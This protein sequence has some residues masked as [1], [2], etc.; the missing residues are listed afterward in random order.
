MPGR[1]NQVALRHVHREVVQDDS[2]LHHVLHVHFSLKRLDDDGLVLATVE[3]IEHVGCVAFERLLTVVLGQ[4]ALHVQYL[5]HEINDTV[6]EVENDQHGFGAGEALCEVTSLLNLV[7]DGVEDAAA[8]DQRLEL[9]AEHAKRVGPRH[10]AVVGR[11]VM[12]Q[13]LLL[14][15]ILRELEPEII[16]GILYVKVSLAGDELLNDVLAPRQ[17]LVLPACAEFAA[18][19]GQS[20]RISLVKLLDLPRNIVL[21]FVL[22]GRVVAILG[23]DIVA[24]LGG[25]LASFVEPLGS[26]V[27]EVVVAEDLPHLW[28]VNHVAVVQAVVVGLILVVEL[29]GEVENAQSRDVLVLVVAQEHPQCLDALAPDRA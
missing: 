4:P 3:L 7:E 1:D 15:E 26:I 16:G 18:H 8:G 21:V 2:A 24:Q 6:I 28:Q 11:L 23:L 25:Q 12:R 29:T 27:V 22:V 9:E 14:G 20:E 17:L 19:D 13:L 10:D 5:A